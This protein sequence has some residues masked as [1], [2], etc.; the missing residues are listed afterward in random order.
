MLKIILFCLI[1]IC[2]WNLLLAVISLIYDYIYFSLIKHYI[3]NDSYE[4]AFKLIDNL[5]EKY[6][7]EEKYVEKMQEFYGVKK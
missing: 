6:G 1:V 2:A 7:S 5:V 3:A 4:K